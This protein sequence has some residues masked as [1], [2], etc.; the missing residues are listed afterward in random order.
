MKELLSGMLALTLV[1]SLFT[2]AAV[3]AEVP[4]DEIIGEIFYQDGGT[5]SASVASAAADEQTAPASILS[6]V[7]NPD[8]SITIYEYENNILIGAHTTVPVSGGIDSVYYDAA[9]NTTTEIE[10]TKVQTRAAD[11]NI[12][13]EVNF[14]NLGYMHYRNTLPI[15]STLLIAI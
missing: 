12:P 7:T 5:E 9:G 13:D 14:R 15:L 1:F 10:F 4:T 11:T 6:S 3:A 2:P 8:G